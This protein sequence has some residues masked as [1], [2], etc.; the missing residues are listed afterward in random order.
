MRNKENPDF[1][2]FKRDPYDVSQ[3]RPLIAAL[4]QDWLLDTSRQTTYS[5]HRFTSSYF[6]Q[7]VPIMEW[8]KGEALNILTRS[9]NS[10]LWGLVQPI[11]DDLENKCDGKVG[12]ALFIALGKGKE[13]DPH[14]DDGEYLMTTQRHHIPIFTNDRVRFIVDDESQYMAVGECWEINNNKR[15]AVTNLGPTDR[16]HLLIDII[17]NKFLP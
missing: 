13:I 5:T 1:K 12:Q 15:H 17:P 6:M 10:K 8:K 7:K 9:D 3:I 4:N 14:Y 2:F 11:I 16:V